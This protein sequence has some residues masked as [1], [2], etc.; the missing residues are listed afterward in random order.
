ML[1]LGKRMFGMEGGS[2]D[3]SVEETRRESFESDDCRNPRHRPRTYKEAVSPLLRVVG[4]VEEDLSE[5][6]PRQM[7]LV[8]IGWV[9]LTLLP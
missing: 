9:D 5:P 3:G 4:G 8:H 6:P 2:R 7:K 1:A